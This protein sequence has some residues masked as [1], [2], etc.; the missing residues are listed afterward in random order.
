MMQFKGHSLLRSKT[1][2]GAI[3][4]AGGWLVSQP[5]VGVAEVVQAIGTVIGAAG[6]RDAFRK[7]ENAIK[8][9]EDI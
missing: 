4:A 5:A 1:V 3:F 2:W 9:T 8:F 6:V 7:T